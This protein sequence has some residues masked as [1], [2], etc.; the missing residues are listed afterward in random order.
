MLLCIDDLPFSF[1]SSLSSGFLRLLERWA[2]GASMGLG[3]GVRA[4]VTFGTA[5]LIDLLSIPIHRI[6]I[7]WTADNVET[8]K[9]KMTV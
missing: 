7:G 8:V 9:L 4:S 5:E 3:H 6:A 2:D 1:C